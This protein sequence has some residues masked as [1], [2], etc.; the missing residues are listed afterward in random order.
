MKKM[1]E[2]SENFEEGKWVV[3]RERILMGKEVYIQVNN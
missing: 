2:W 3:S 1:V